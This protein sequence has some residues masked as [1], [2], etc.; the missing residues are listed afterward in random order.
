MNE[1]DNALVG[2]GSPENRAT[3][4]T[5]ALFSF[6]SILPVLLCQIVLYFYTFWI[7]YSLFNYLIKL[8]TY[9]LL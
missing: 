3:K 9:I 1:K 5:A 4:V 6:F 2:Q 7:L 8:F